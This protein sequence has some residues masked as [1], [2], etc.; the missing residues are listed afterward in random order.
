M[1][2]TDAQ[3]KALISARDYGNPCFHLRGRSEF[4]G[5]QRT[6][7]FLLSRQLVDVDWKITEAGR[8]ALAHPSQEGKTP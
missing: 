6:I 2:F 5:F 8:E 1:K 4:G 7:G 3:R